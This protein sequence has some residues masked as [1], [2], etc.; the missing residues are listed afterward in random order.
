MQPVE[1]DKE[2]HGREEKLEFFTDVI[3]IDQMRGGADCGGRIFA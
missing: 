1:G 2:L 3:Y